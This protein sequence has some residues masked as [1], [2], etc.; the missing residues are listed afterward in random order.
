MEEKTKKRWV[1]R[2]DSKRTWLHE[3]ISM[4]FAL[5]MIL[6]T[7]MFCMHAM[8]TVAQYEMN[9]PCPECETCTAA[10]IEDREGCERVQ[11]DN[12]EVFYLCL[13]E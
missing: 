1:D 4:I 3:P 6:S 5:V 12:G 7:L 2:I 8:Q 9:A 10:A 11:K 13:P